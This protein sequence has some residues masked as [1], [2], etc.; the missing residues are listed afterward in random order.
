[1]TVT[2]DINSEL[3]LDRDHPLLESIKDIKII[4]VDTH[5]T[6][7]GDLWT[8]RAPSKYRDL[9]PR[10][11]HVKN[12]ELAKMGVFRPKNTEDSETSPVWMAGEDIPLGFA[13]GASVINKSNRKVRGA[14]FVHWPL[15]EVSPAAS[16]VEPRLTLMDEVGIW[17]QILY[18]NAVG[19]GGQAMAQIQD[20][21]LRLTVLR[22]W[23]DAMAEMQEQSGGRIMGLGITPWWDIDLA[24][25]EVQRI[26]DLGLHGINT[27]ADPH[28]QGH[29]DLSEPYYAPFWDACESLDLSVN[30]HIGASVSQTSYAGNSPWPSL[31]WDT[32][33]AMGSTMLYIYNARVISNIIY[34]GLLD[35]HPTSR[36]SPSRAVSGGSRSSST[37]WTT[38]PSRTTSTTCR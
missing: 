29:P 37:P 4:D 11:V 26:H 16:L 23:N 10:V 36:S 9:V 1:M 2:D 3:P 32:K 34:S 19:F 38:R 15:T 20:P 6:E 31:D 7:P 13:G 25:A 22:I 35:R 28:N 14:D 27:N 12:S 17:G 18:P 21:E 24:V 30:F 33:I 5:L 8:S